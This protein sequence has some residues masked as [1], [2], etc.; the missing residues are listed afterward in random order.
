MRHLRNYGIL[1]PIF[2]LVIVLVVINM[3]NVDIGMSH[4]I[5]SAQRASYMHTP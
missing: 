3:K 4:I 2:T 5:P 1:I